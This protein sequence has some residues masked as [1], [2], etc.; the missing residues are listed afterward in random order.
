MELCEFSSAA[1]AAMP[2]VH[3]DQERQVHEQRILLGLLLFIARSG[4][5]LE[6]V[7]QPPRP[8]AAAPPHALVGVQLVA[9]AVP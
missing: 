8:V 6:P 1:G 2:G 5:E 7:A 9:I 3:V 4:L